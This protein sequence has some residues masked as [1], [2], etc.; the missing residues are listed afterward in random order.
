MA[1][2]WCR[3]AVFLVWAYSQSF[4]VVS[5]STISV[6]QA[7]LRLF[8]LSAAACVAL[9]IA[10]TSI[11]VFT[12]P[13]AAVCSV[14][15]GTGTVFTPVSGDT[16]TCDTNAPNPDAATVFG[17]AADNVT[18]IL[19]DGA[20][21]ENDA[22]SGTITG[23]IRLQH[24]ATVT[25]GDG[26]FIE[27]TGRTTG[28]IQVSDRGV[29]DLGNNSRIIADY[30][31]SDGVFARDN[32]TVT[33][34]ENAVVTVMGDAAR[35][36]TLRNN[37]TL[38]LE[39]GAVVT[40]TGSAASGT[41]GRGSRG[42]LVRDG[43]TVTLRT[44]ARVVTTGD[45]AD[46]ITLRHDNTLILEGT[47]QVSVSGGGSSAI[48]AAASG[49][50]TSQVLNLTIRA[51]ASAIATGD[52]APAGA[53]LNAHA[54]EFVAG[55]INLEGTARAN[56]GNAISQSISGPATQFDTTINIAAGAVAQS[57]QGHGIFLYRGAADVTVAGSVTGGGGTAI[58]LGE[59]TGRLELQPG[60][61][62]VGIVDAGLGNDTLVFGGVGSANFDISGVGD[63]LD[64]RRF[65]LFVKEDASVFTFTNTG[66][67][68]NL[69]VNGGEIIN[70]G[71]LTVLTAIDNNLGA[72][73]TSTGAVAGGIINDGAVNA[74]GIFNGTI[75]NQGVGT[76][77][78]TGDLM[79]DGSDFTNSG[80][81]VLNVTG[82]NFSGLGTVTNSST[83]STG[84]RVGAGH[85]LAAAMFV[86]NA[87]STTLVEGVLDAGP[88]SVSGL[89][90]L[91][92]AGTTTASSITINAG[93]EVRS[94]GGGLSATA[95]ISLSGTLDVDGDETIATLTGN[96]NAEIA[97]GQTLTFGDGSD[98]IFGG[99]FS[100]PGSSSVAKQGAGE[101]TLTGNSTGYPGSFN[102]NQGSLNLRGRWGGGIFGADGTT[103]LGNGFAGR[104]D[105]ASGATVAPGTNGTIDTLSITG[106]LNLAVGSFYNVDV[107]SDGTSDL[108]S[109]GGT[110]TI[111]G[112]TVN[113]SA[114]GNSMDYIVG[115]Q[116][117][118]VT[119]GTE[120]T[121]TFDAVQDNSAFLDFD[122]SYDAQNVYLTANLQPGSPG[123]GDGGGGDSGLGI[124]GSAGLT[125]NQ[126]QAG[127]GADGLDDSPD[128]ILIRNALLLL[129]LEEARAAFDAIAAEVHAEGSASAFNSA[130]DFVQFL[131]SFAGTAENGV[132]T[133]TLSTPNPARFGTG[134]APDRPASETLVW[135]G[136]FG[137][138][139]EVDSDGNAG[140][141]E[142]AVLGLAGG[143][144]MSSAELDVT[145]GASLGYSHSLYDVQGR[146][147]DGE[148]M[149]V[150]AGL[151]ARIGADRLE[152]GLG[153]RVALAYSHHWLD[154]TRDIAFGTI[155]R[156]AEA[157]YTGYSLTGDVEARYNHA[158]GS[159]QTFVS[160]FVRI[161]F[162]R[163]DLG[164]FTETGAGALNLTGDAKTYDRATAAVG[165]AVSGERNL[166]GHVWR[167]SIS[168]AY[169][170]AAGAEPETELTLQASPNRFVT[171]GADESH[172]RVRFGTL[173][174]F[175][176]TDTASMTFGTDS[177]WSQDRTEISAKAGA[178]FRF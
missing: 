62:I 32:A 124:F 122:L 148:V 140:G 134:L 166:G 18:V 156:R 135:F 24:D 155:N 74:R 69:T 59:D 146:M 76:F 92:G 117:T 143:V 79:S 101:V 158:I 5:S 85:T 34:G 82:G 9:A 2:L 110:A 129:S 71:S 66:T 67:L 149:S 91:N 153:S 126:I 125:P 127:I 130:E 103:V 61:S 83:A 22:G 78:V 33:V 68:P 55:T 53:F 100:G 47:A 115:Q 104:L 73:F 60:F 173:S 80:T 3:G 81:A 20:G 89:I 54:I 96:G 10:T 46:G 170:Y 35:G 30:A 167:P 102:L 75:V 178:K 162:G 25:L 105:L 152:E 137:G 172:H 165:L 43:N 106:N 94:D 8:E 133:A 44:G 86:S 120:V 168:V 17:P 63:A 119:A 113:V 123:G 29:I 177:V 109:I 45:F 159:D 144:E 116:F 51:G 23:A 19:N 72:T 175:A 114:L 174:E 157:D 163:T 37:S 150:H 111:S 40:T 154:T 160:P 139:G 36:I 41:T 171:W 132:S 112:G 84:V 13:A 145:F 161:A 12:Q 136:G 56:G 14:T 49:T 147:Q 38:T 1:C 57:T 16:I 90:N 169:E 52:V 15:T 6:R 138:Y 108:L 11:A 128:A 97:A 121:G 118:I 142:N 58:D 21:I 87:G 176:I 4:G 99:T 27:Q 65:E 107:F 31:P 7:A 98:F 28:G 164:S 42:I 50:N 26:A 151:Y 141:Y 88:L 93:G 70:T 64:Y 131:M 95:N 48:A 77:T 39:A